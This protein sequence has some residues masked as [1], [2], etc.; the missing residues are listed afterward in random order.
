[1]GSVL[2][3]STRPHGARLRSFPICLFPIGFNPRARMGRDQASRLDHRS[4]AV[5]IHAPA[6]GATPHEPRRV[7]KPSKFQSTRPHGARPHRGD[8]LLAQG[9]VSIHAPAWGATRADEVGRMARIV[10]IHAPAWGATTSQTALG[11]DCAF[12]S[13]RPHGA[14][15]QRG[16]RFGN[17]RQFQS[18]RPHGARLGPGTSK[19]GQKCFNPR[20]RMGRDAQRA[21][22]L[23]VNCR[24]QSTRPHG[25][26]LFS[27]Y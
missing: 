24:F 3:Q 20:A 10:S 17:G 18:T 15:H 27:R 5:S 13:T 16:S 12:Q 26:R 9:L 25:A 21:V 2:F 23:C 8:Q 22:L 19:G 1:M 4:T 6:W 14:R 7:G 11:R